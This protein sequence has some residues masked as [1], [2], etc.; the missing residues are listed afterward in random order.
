MSCHAFA[1]DAQ[2]AKHYHI[3]MNEGGAQNGDEMADCIKDVFNA[4]EVQKKRVFVHCVWGKHRTG[5]F[6]SLLKAPLAQCRSCDFFEIRR[7]L[8]G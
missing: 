3:N 2:A 4:L 6:I 5:A 7:G 8:L 1:G